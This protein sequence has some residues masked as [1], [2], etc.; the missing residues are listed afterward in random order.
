L[1]GPPKLLHSATVPAFLI[2]HVMFIVYSI[3]AALCFTVGAVFMK[4]AQGMTQWVPALV[5]LVLFMAG[6]AL[7]G[8]A[9]RGNEMGVTHIFILGLEAVLA[10]GLAAIYLHEPVTLAKAGGVAL[11]IAGMATLRM[12]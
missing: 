11:V 5:C 7:Q 9:M 4:H 3:L 1:H 2:G 8:L 12:A 10:L 6:A